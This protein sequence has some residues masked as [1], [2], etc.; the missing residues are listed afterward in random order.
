VTEPS[1]RERAVAVARELAEEGG[2]DA[3]A[4]RTVAERSGSA[5]AT[6]YREFPSKTHLVLAMADSELAQVPALTPD[7]V[8]RVGPV[9]LVARVLGAL[10]NGALQRPSYTAAVL[11]AALTAGSDAAD[12]VNRLRGRLA[13][14]LMSCLSQ[15]TPQDV[16]RLDLLI[17]VWFAEL[18]ATVHDRQTPEGCTRLLTNAA[19]L[20][21]ADHVQL[22][23]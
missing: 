17:D 20:V 10:T 4:M 22:D 15:P 9:H 3:V 16:T 2:W 5:L 6:L 14:L 7:D 19:G 21:L 23:A 8:A 1:R 13:D 18:L 12:D 11:H